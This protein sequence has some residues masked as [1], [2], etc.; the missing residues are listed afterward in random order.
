MVKLITQFSALSLAVMAPI[1]S[2]VD[3]LLRVHAYQVNYD[4]KYDVP[5]GKCLNTTTSDSW[6]GFNDN[7]T[8]SQI[9]T[10]GPVVYA[11]ITLKMSVSS[12]C[13]VA[14]MLNW[15]GFLDTMTSSH[16]FFVLRV[17]KIDEKTQ[18]N[19]SVHLLMKK[20]LFVKTEWFKIRRS[21]V[22]NPVIGMTIHVP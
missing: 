13:S 8:R 16:R 14:A 20:A 3:I 10:P 6:T 5:I 9:Q 12:Y 17:L 11:I 21:A 15:T 18:W 7:V 1:V 22:F 4:W 19:L 2:A